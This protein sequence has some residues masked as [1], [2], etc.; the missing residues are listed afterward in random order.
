MT[1]ARTA[2]LAGGRRGHNAGRSFLVVSIG[3]SVVNVARCLARA[4]LGLSAS[5]LQWVVNAYSIA[6]A[7]FM[8]LGGRA[9]DLFGRKRDVP[10]RPRSVHPR[11]ARRRAHQDDW[12]LLAARAVQGLGAAVPRPLHP[13]HPHPPAVPEGA[14]RAQAIATWTAVGAGGG[15]AGGLVGGVLT[16]G[17]ELALRVLLV[18]CRSAP[19]SSRGAAPL[20]QEVPRGRRAR[21]LSTCRARCSSPRARRPL[22]I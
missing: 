19:S 6:F 22:Y 1:E 2:H 9:G 15:A 3:V 8:L 10:G 14:A 13:D 12:R 16:E 5:G 20:D 4:D 11:L 18:A 7:G 17:P 21:R